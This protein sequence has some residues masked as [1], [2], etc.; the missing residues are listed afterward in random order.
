MSNFKWLE[1]KNS[2]DYVMELIDHWMEEYT[3]EEDILNL[4]R[5][6]NNIKECPQI[7]NTFMPY[8]R[9]KT[10]ANVFIKSYLGNMTK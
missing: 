7:A 2:F 6:K 5:M 10:T 8:V 3:N 1:E 9:N 4:K